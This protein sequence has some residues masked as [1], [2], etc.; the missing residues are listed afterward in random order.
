M[1]P[2]KCQRCRVETAFPRSCTLCHIVRCEECHINHSENGVC[3]Y[4]LVEVESEKTTVFGT[5]G[6]PQDYEMTHFSVPADES[7]ISRIK[8]VIRDNVVRLATRTKTLC[9]NLN[10]RYLLPTFVIP[11]IMAFLLFFTTKYFILKNSLS[12]L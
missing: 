7:R 5:L 11:I 6:L 8:A 4:P 2:M 3:E 12:K 9:S 10:F 1:K